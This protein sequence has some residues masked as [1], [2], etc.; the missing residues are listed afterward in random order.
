[1]YC[2]GLVKAVDAWHTI[3]VYRPSAGGAGGLRETEIDNILSVLSGNNVHAGRV[4][5]LGGV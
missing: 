4:G 1:M 5:G 2:N 3:C